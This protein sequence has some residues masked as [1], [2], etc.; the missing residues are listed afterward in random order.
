[1]KNWSIS[2]KLLCL[3][4]IAIVTF[5]G[6]GLYGIANTRS[7][8]GWVREVNLTAQDFQRSAKELSDP[9]HRV[10]ELTLSIVL[11]PDRAFL[12]K[13]NTAREKES[14]GRDVILRRRALRGMLSSE[15]NAM[16]EKV[17]CI[18]TQT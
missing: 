18:T 6:M 9:L 2:L 13:L 14:G 3:V 16:R 4:A 11:A 12:E 10:R 15:R 5:V 17:R 8:F 7:I 1:M